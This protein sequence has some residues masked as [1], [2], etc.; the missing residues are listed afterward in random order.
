MM[1]MATCVMV[2]ANPVVLK[3][4]RLHLR[5]Y[6]MLANAEEGR[7]AAFCAK[8][9]SHSHGYF[10]PPG[11]VRTTDEQWHIFDFVKGDEFEAPEA[12]R[13]VKRGERVFPPTGIWSG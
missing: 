2:P 13:K 4:L 10:P 3:Y 6:S 9:R 5:R 11:G 12:P 8:V 7:F 1:T